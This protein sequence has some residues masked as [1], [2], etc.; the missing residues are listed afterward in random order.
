LARLGSL[1]I[2]L[3]CTH[4]DAPHSIS[5]SEITASLFD[6]AEFGSRPRDGS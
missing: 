4:C 3:W 1:K 5:A 2:S 6:D